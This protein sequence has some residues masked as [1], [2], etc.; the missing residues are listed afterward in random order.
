MH[1]KP[2]AYLDGDASKSAHQLFDLFGSEQ[3]KR[4]DDQNASFKRKDK[5]TAFL[6][7]FAMLADIGR[8]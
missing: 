8:L 1:N 3:M 6:R 5:K 4:S 2:E 7:P